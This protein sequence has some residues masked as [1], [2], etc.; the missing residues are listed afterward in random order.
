MKFEESNI[1][2]MKKVRMNYDLSRTGD[3]DI[4]IIFIKGF[5]SDKHNPKPQTLRALGYACE[6]HKNGKRDNG[7]PYMVHPLS[8]VCFAIGLGLTDDNL[9]ATILLHDVVEDTDANIDGLPVNMAVKQSVKYLTIGDPL[10]GESKEELKR[11]YFYSLLEN[12]NALL[13]KALDRYSNLSTMAGVFEIDRIKKNVKE[14]KNLLLP[15]LKAAKDIYTEFS[16][17][18]HILREVI[19]IL[20]LNLAILL[21]EDLY[22]EDETT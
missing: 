4:M 3:T 19:K 16:N 13:T 11:R 20:N 1:E 18:I 5:C 17:E 8:M 14:T 21:G 2:E 15:V 22:A 12:L 9:L 6:K 7:E 10:P